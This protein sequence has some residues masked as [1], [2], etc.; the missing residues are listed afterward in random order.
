[1][2]NRELRD[3]VL[4]LEPYPEDLKEKIREKIIHTKER[5][6]KAW[7]RPLHAFFCVAAGMALLGGV[8]AI[9]V[10]FDIIVSRAPTYLLVALPVLVLLLCWLIVLLLMSLKKGVWGSRWDSY[11]VFP[12]AGFVL[13]VVVATMLTDRGVQGDDLAGLIVVVGCVIA[14]LVKSSELRLC[15]RVLRNELA[16]AELA[17]LIADRAAGDPK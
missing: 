10:Y 6:L 13:Y 7:E 14:T 3:K 15:E 1:M 4:E 2:S 5:P 17:E 11:I 12:A 8:G 9:I 16:L